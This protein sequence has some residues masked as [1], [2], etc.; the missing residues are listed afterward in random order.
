MYLCYIDESGTSDTPGNTSHFVLA[1]VS[2]PIWHWRDAD[3]DIMA[4]KIR[5]GLADEEI[6]TAWLLRKYLEQSRI[7]NFDAL[8]RAQRRSEVTKSRTSHLLQ[9]QKSNSNRA[10]RQARKNYAHTNAY[11]HLTL[12]ERQH[13]VEEVADCVSRWGFARLFA[14]CINKCHFDPARAQRSVDEQA[15]EQVVSR[16]EQYLQNTGDTNGQRNY[17]LIVHDNNE[18]VERKHTRL[19][20][21]FHQKGTLWTKIERIIETPLFVDSQ[22][23]SMVQIADLCS[24]ALRRFVENGET[25]LFNKIHTRADRYHGRVVGVRHF[26]DQVCQCE[27]CKGH[28]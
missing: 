10:Y 28:R 17:G 19:M 1:G 3:R 16:F 13:L 12:Q 15:F 22:L 20:R 25:R 5:Y 2:L 18:T 23:T 14:E 21:S 9:L 7:N 4:I 6:H 24:Y 8:S 11:I 26:T 27:I